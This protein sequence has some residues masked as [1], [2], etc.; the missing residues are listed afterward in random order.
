LPRETLHVD[1]L[2]A[3]V[4]ASDTRKPDLVFRIRTS[5]TSAEALAQ[6]RRADC[7]EAFESVEGTLACL[8]LHQPLP[9]TVQLTPASHACW[10]L[11]FSR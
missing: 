9:P 6:H 8:S 7:A 5:L 1:G 11:R 10:A 2:L 3:V 4:Q